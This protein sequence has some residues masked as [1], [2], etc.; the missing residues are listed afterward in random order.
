[1]NRPKFLDQRMVEFSGLTQGSGLAALPGFISEIG[2][3][4]PIAPWG[5]NSL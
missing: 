2:T 1:M 3:L 5:R 4:L